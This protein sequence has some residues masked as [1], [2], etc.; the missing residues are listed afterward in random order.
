VIHFATVKRRRSSKCS[1]HRPPA[2][3]RAG[4]DH[5]AKPNCYRRRARGHSRNGRARLTLRC[6]SHVSCQLTPC[7]CRRLVVYEQYEAPTVRPAAPT[8]EPHLTPGTEVTMPAAEALISQTVAI[9]C[10][11]PRPSPA[12][13]KPSERRR[14]GIALGRLDAVLRKRFG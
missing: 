7:I 3:R 13:V 10:P 2:R 4:P 1:R 9:E 11:L 12:W 6:Y 8:A 5:R 14:P